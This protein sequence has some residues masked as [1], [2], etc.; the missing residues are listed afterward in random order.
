MELVGHT[1]GRYELTELLG[2]GGMA[3][4]YKARDPRL[5]RDVA[6]KVIL[7]ETQ[8]NN[9]FL[10]RFELEARALAQLSH[11]NIVTILD[12]GEHDNQPYLVMQYISGGTLKKRLG[13]PYSWQ[14]ATAILLPI[15][16]S[17]NYAHLRSII[18]RDVKPANI[19]I[20]ETGQPMLSD[21]GIAKIVTGSEM[22][23]LTTTHYMSP[24][25]GL[26]QKVDG[27]TDIYSLGV[28]LYELVTGQR[29]FEA[30]TPMQLV[31]KHATIAPRPPR[32]LCPDL[33]TTVE[34]I[35]ARAMAKEPNDRYP[36]MAEFI[37]A[38]EELNNSSAQARGV[39]RQTQPMFE[40]LTAVVV[41]SPSTTAAT[42]NASAPA[43]PVIESTQI[44]SPVQSRKRWVS[45]L[46]TTGITTAVVALVVLILLIIAAYAGSLV[47]SRAIEQTASSTTM[48]T[49]TEAETQTLTEDEINLGIMNA[50][51]PYTLDYILYTK[52]DFTEPD[53]IEILAMTN[54]EPLI[55]QMT[56]NQ[57]DGY[58]HVLFRS[59]N[60]F[61]LLFIGGI[62]SQGINNGLRQAMDQTGVRIDGL[63]IN[64]Y[65]LTYT[66][67]PVR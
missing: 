66:V 31:L 64:G 10:K 21:F 4:V 17:L 39:A 58:P 45:C 47:I 65:N 59:L 35:I 51:Q 19:L 36:D 11:P 50:I 5:G 48:Y 22:V 33:P 42:V 18:H 6:V 40:T 30:D 41:R 60:K 44:Q 8:H 32:E 26:G 3:E 38:L 15:A 9:K 55:V 16:H 7:S 27:R 29:P 24:E 34:N 28:I 12:Y 61:P 57:V 25:Q 43:S 53:S 49:F 13:Q 63:T 46:I 20:S 54:G 67:T 52:V 62:F 56:I 37:Q 1:L 14:D 23:D 2:R